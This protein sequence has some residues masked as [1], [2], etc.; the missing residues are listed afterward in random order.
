M[1]GPSDFDK[2]PAE[3]IQRILSGL[4]LKSLS[5]VA[6]AS[7]Q[8]KAHAAVVQPKI[9]K[10]TSIIHKSGSFVSR[11][12]ITGMALRGHQDAMIYMIITQ[13]YSGAPHA[14]TIQL[15]DNLNQ[16]L[17]LS[18]FRRLAPALWPRAENSQKHV[19]CIYFSKLPGKVGKVASIMLQDEAHIY[20]AIAEA[21]FNPRNHWYVPLTSELMPRLTIKLSNRLNVLCSWLVEV[22]QWQVECNEIANE[23][24]RREILL[25]AVYLCGYILSRLYSKAVL[26]LQAYGIIC[27]AIAGKCHSGMSITLNHAAWLTD[28]SV[29]YEELVTITTEILSVTPSLFDLRIPEVDLSIFSPDFMT[30]QQFDDMVTHALSRPVF[31]HKF[32]PAA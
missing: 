24:Q 16:Y 9:I 2:L 30:P 11:K 4:D 6:A 28:N 10:E 18:L 23:M 3:M 22:S 13:I 19:V 1:D 25:K 27:F 31:G 21:T 12:K 8:M 14:D 15:L 20:E 26:S 32:N 29:I 17:D 7:K 5:S